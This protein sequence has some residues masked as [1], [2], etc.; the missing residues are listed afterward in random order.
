MFRTFTTTGICPK[1]TRKINFIFIKIATI[2][3]VCGIYRPPY[4]IR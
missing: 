3:A 1:R 4:F 2:T